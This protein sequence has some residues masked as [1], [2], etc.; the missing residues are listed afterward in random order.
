MRL[1][2]KSKNIFYKHT[3]THTHTHTHIYTGNKYLNKMEK[4]RINKYESVA[5]YGGEEIR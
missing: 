4:K 2:G 1:R 3:H 5:I